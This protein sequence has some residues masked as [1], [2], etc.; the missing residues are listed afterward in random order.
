M[1]SRKAHPLSFSDE[2]PE[3]IASVPPLDSGFILT[4]PSD[5]RYKFITGLKHRFGEFLHN[6]SVSLR[7]QGEENTLDAVQMLVNY[8]SN[9]FFHD[10]SLTGLLRSGQSELT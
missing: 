3:M 8:L 2:I 9:G 5:P 1:R 10:Q 7:S 6:A 4:D